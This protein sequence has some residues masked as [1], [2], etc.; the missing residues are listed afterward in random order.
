[1][2]SWVE[3]SPLNQTFILFF[4]SMWLKEHCVKI[5]RVLNFFNYVDIYVFVCRFEVRLQVS[6]EAKGIRS[7]GAA[8]ADTC[9][10]ER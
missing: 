10:P 9:R 2:S 4:L 5:C 6:K 3:C 8:V 1:M 7:Y